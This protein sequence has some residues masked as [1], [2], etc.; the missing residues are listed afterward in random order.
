MHVEGFGS[1]EPTIGLVRGLDRR[2]W[3]H[4]YAV[5]RHPRGELVG[6]LGSLGRDPGDGRIPVWLSTEGRLLTAGQQSQ[7]PSVT[8]LARLRWM[9]A[10]LGWR[11]LPHSLI[12]RATAVAQRSVRAWRGPARRAGSQASAV[13]AGYLESR[14]WPGALAL[15]EATHPVMWDQLL[16][17]NRWEA[18]DL[19]YG[20]PTLLGYLGPYAPVTGALGTRR[21]LLPWAT[22]FGQEVR[23]PAPAGIAAGSLDPLDLR[24]PGVRPPFKVRGW[25]LAATGP[26]AR[27]EMSVKGH[28]VGRARL[29]I[30]RPDLSKASTRPDAPVCGFEFLFLPEHVGEH[31]GTVRLGATAYG[32]DGSSL[33]WEMDVALG[34]QSTDA[35]DGSPWPTPARR[36]AQRTAGGRLGVLAATHDLGYGGA[37]LYLLEL[38][39]RLVADHG[40]D[41][42]VVSAGDGPLR[43]MLENSEIAV[44]RT[45]AYPSNRLEAYREWVE[46]L[47]ATIGSRGVDLVV[48]NTVLAFPGIDLARA[49]GAPSILAVH[50]SFEAS[51]LE[52]NAFG[53]SYVHPDVQARLR[54]AIRGADLLVFEAEATRQQYEALVRPDRT[55]TLPYGIELEALDRFGAGFDRAQ[56]RAALGIDAEDTVVL[57]LGTVEPRKAQVLLVQAF[58]VLAS[59]YPSARLILV[60]EHDAPYAAPYSAALREH[61]TRAGLEARVMILPVD[62]DPWRWHA[63]ADV[64]ACVSDLESLPR[65]VLE[66]MAFE[67]TVL[68]SDV[69]GLP[70]VIE[71]GLTGYLC[72]SNHVEDIARALDTVLGAPAHERRAVAA[73]GAELVRRDHD[74]ASYAERFARLATRVT[75]DPRRSPVGVPD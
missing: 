27:V 71:D 24:R 43:T 30:A 16:T 48:A 60:G 63:I 10:P 55:L 67:S 74:A 17:S 70:E 73:R 31:S 75:E 11:G 34:G 65:S 21:P 53:G 8:P 58:G 15:Y 50:E 39:S 68:A 23:S 36:P 18:V 57:C 69:F 45:R 6:E 22:R 1:S 47:A 66:A 44:H 41:C 9:A 5:G 61:I 12:H 51:S 59:R 2:S 32:L 49:L 29:G 42:T 20:E 40:F 64:Y 7:H 37:Q 62:P 56:A 25:A 72:A 52:Y 38:L 35:P 3:R 19:G 46:E 14:A 13:P 4:T 28:Q 33:S 26:A 54:A